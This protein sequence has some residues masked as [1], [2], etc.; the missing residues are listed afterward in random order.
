MDANRKSLMIDI[1]TLSLSEQAYILQIGAVL[2]SPTGIH[3]EFKST[4][5]EEGQEFR[6]ITSKSV[7]FW[8]KNAGAIDEVELSEEIPLPKALEDL[9]EFIVEHEP[10][11]IWA[12]SPEFDL[13]VLE[14][15]F[16][17]QGMV[18]PWTYQQKR[19]VRTVEAL[20]RGV[21]SPEDVRFQGMKHNALDDARHQAEYTR[22]MVQTLLSGL[23]R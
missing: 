14:H 18:I 5:S 23:H 3:A 9:S 10:A 11:E 13:A 6:E 21:V 16:M 7:N 15:A 22:L 1:E 12:R 4:L 2:F 8:L 19:D 20:C 17:T